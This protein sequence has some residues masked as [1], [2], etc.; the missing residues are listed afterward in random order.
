MYRVFFHP[1]LSA[2]A[3]SVA[4]SLFSQN[5]MAQSL[6]SVTAT[7]LGT[8]A[9]NNAGNSTANAVSAGGSVAVGDASLR[10][11]LGTHA[12]RWTSAGMTDLGTLAK[13][14]AG[15]STA[16]GV[17]ADGN[18][19][20]GSASTDGGDTRAFRWT[21]QGMVSLGTLA[22][23]NA[24]SSA[25]R[26]ISAGGGV[27]AGSASTGNG[28]SRAFRWTSKGMTDLG[29]LAKGNAG[30]S[31]AYG[32][33]S[34][35]NIVVGSASSDSAVERAFRWTSEGMTDLGALAIGKVNNSVAAAVS[36][37]GGVIAGY[38][39]NNDGVTTMRAVRWDS[40][41]MADLGT[42][43]GN[44]GTSQ[45][46]A[47]S[48][49]GGTIG[50]TASSS[51]GKLHAFLWRAETGM[52][53]LTPALLQRSSTVMGI[54]AD[55]TVAAGVTQATNIGPW[56][57]KAALW[58]ITWKQAPVV[59]PSDITSPPVV[60]PPDVTS[61]PVVA[62]PEVRMVYVDNARSS[63]W[64]LA[65][66]TFNVME[67]VRGGL[68]ARRNPCDVDAKGVICVRGG[69]TYQAIKHADDQSA[70]LSMGYGLTDKVSAGI[71]LSTSLT[72]NLPESYR[73]SG[74]NISVGA[75]TRW[76]QADARGAWFATLSGAAAQSRTDIRM[77]DRDYSD[78]GN[79]RPDIR[80]WS[81]SL[82]AGREMVLGPS[83]TGRLSGGF[84]H[85]E[86]TRQRYTDKGSAFPFT[87]DA[88]RYRLNYLF[89]SVGTDVAVT[90]KLR[91]VSRAHGE[92]DVTGGEV[93]FRASSLYLGDV[94]R[95][96]KI[97][98]TRWNIGSGL[99][100]ALTPVVSVSVIPWAGN[101]ALGDMSY[102]GNA[103]LTAR[104]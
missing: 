22:P 29:T 44:V 94:S 8:F 74:N 66:E 15:S 27:V 55:G 57:G 58:K 41:G 61:P 14:N 25:A 37:N 2:L 4:A 35:G 46:L 33:S 95:T 90:Q 60:T 98:H 9:P 10:S 76:R 39:Y 69:T 97:T 6:P 34:D 67:L 54:N 26:A 3:V 50:G 30:T 52:I 48:A 100:Y 71:L 70:S 102:G 83:V 19:V 7:T 56:W 43:K 18:I 40:G 103:S 85:D 77:K 24:G 73:H 82:E 86:V 89:V 11:G 1:S 21:P 93:A 96:A 72:G 13:G 38:S 20:V 16:Y 51:A 64:R 12:F 81:A 92:Q 87:Y 101:S 91:W 28:G 65:G 68:D 80:G 49:D 75:W 36:A 32:V 17:S 99:V 45:A 42:L 104:F 31:T 78:P 63:R 79:A 5:G 23:G 53:D 62:P 47:I 84:S 59:T 88:A